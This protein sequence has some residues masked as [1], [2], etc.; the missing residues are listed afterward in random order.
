MR[1]FV[2]LPLGSS[3]CD[4]IAHVSE[5]LKSRGAGFRWTAREAWHITLQFLGNATP[6][7]LA[8][9]V[10][11]LGLGLFDRAGVVFIE[12]ELSPELLALQTKI[13]QA[14]RCCGFQPEERPYHPHITL[15]RAKSKPHRHEK[16]ALETA[17][18]PA[19]HFS[20]SVATEFL[21]YESFLGPGGS[22]Y[23]IRGQFPLIPLGTRL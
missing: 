6:D 22:R 4:E 1:L 5:R 16:Q 8:D 15:A 17:V 14:T 21:L 11:H 23:E 10:A 13:V 9:L 7:R 19:V 18:Q 12:V 20:G 2:A 3:T